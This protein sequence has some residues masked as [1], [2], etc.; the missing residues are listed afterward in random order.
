MKPLET[1][2]DVKYYD[3]TKKLL[4]RCVLMPRFLGVVLTPCVYPKLSTL[5][6][7]SQVQDVNFCAFSFTF[8]ANLLSATI[9]TSE[10][11]NEKEKE[12]LFESQYYYYYY[13]YCGS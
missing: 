4:S 13:Y 8:G 5:T 12:V 10:Y 3:L 7:S 6:L 2:M 1:N 9:D 11:V